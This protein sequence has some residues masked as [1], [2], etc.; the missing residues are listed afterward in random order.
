M[1][2]VRE[3]KELKFL[4][5]VK[6]YR[7]LNKPGFYSICDKKTGI[8]VAYAPSVAIG[9]V[10][11]FHVSE[12]SRQRV[13]RDK[14]RNVHAWVEGDFLGASN[15]ATIENI[16]LGNLEQIKQLKKGY[17]NPYFTD[18]FIDFDSQEPIT[19]ANLVICHD[20]FAFYK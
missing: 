3:G 14:R 19:Q 13:L 20:K 7:N 17:Y 16:C 5:R 1:L 11:K 12:K 9:G 2:N 6:V 4:Q 18:A 10:L 8:V 15:D